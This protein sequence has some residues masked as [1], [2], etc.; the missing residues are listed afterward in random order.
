MKLLNNRC[1][2]RFN[3]IHERTGGLWEGRY[4]AKHV[5]TE[6]YLRICYEYIE[7]NPVRAGFCKR[8]RDYMW[9]SHRYDA[10][11]EYDRVVM[12]HEKYLALAGSD[13]IRRR[14]VPTVVPQ[15]AVGGRA[16]GDSRHRAG[17]CMKSSD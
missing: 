12:P 3:K 4:I 13:K 10:S 17:N 7:L 9:S 6:H 14:R 11:G 16:G 15:G 1:V 2:W 8:A 5:D